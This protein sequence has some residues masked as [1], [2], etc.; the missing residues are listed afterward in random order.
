MHNRFSPDRANGKT[1]R[2]EDNMPIADFYPEVTSIIK[3]VEGS[4]VTI[5]ADVKFYGNDDLICQAELELKGLEKFDYSELDSELTLSP[6]IHTATKDMASFIKK[7]AEEVPI[8]EIRQINK[9]GWHNINGEHCYCTGNRFIG[10]NSRSYCL[11][12]EELSQ[13]YHFDID[14]SISEV[15]AITNIVDIIQIEPKISSILFATGMLGVMRQPILDAGLKVPCITYVCGPTQTR[16]TSTAIECTRIYNK[17]SLQEDAEISSMRVSSTEVRT[18]QITDEL[19]D[20]VF[21]YDDLYKEKNP[22]LR[23]KY[24]SNVRNLLRNFADNSCRN[25]AR[26]AFKN[27]CQVVITGEYLLDSKTDVG[28]LFVV[29]VDQPINSE[30]LRTC[31]ERPLALPT[32]Y[33]YFIEWISENYDTIVERLR[34]EFSE[35]R[36]SE[37]GRRSDYQRLYEQAFLLDFVFTLFLEYAVSKGC[38]LN[39]E[40]FELDFKLNLEEILDEQLKILKHLEQQEEIDINYSKEVVTM[41]RDGTLPLGKKGST[42]FKKDGLIYIKNELLG[43][44]L[45]KKYGRYFSAKDI[46]AYFRKKYISVV[47]HDGRPKKY[48]NKCYLVLKPTELYADAQEQTHRINNLFYNG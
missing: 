46:A 8:K 1:V 42:C 33:L 16:K 36:S 18:E 35:F 41:L 10:L 22:V 11:V 2:S 14:E 6:D 24:E 15:D 28:R 39:K 43:D 19:K 38:P 17:A 30:R 27:N 21:I 7:Q 47:Y 12:N 25:T 9:L 5:K 23:K 48:N 3:Y 20:C 44:K 34:N 45:G 4:N 26:S 40:A 32:F 31:Q 13:K 29:I 37:L